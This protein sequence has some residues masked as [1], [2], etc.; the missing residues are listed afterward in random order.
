MD[1]QKDTLKTLWEKEKLLAT[2]IFSFSHN[3]FYPIKNKNY[4]ISNIWIIV[5]KCSEFGPVQKIVVW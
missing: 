4:K 5:C 1:P 2:D 3:V